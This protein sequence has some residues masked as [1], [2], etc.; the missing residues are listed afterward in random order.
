MTA[1]STVVYGDNARNAQSALNLPDG[2]EQTIT[3]Q[4][5]LEY[6]NVGGYPKLY[7]VIPIIPKETT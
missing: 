6:R 7:I 4:V 2:K 1:I 3:A 5:T